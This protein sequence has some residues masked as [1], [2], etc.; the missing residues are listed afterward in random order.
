MVVDTSWFIRSKEDLQNTRRYGCWFSGDPIYTY[1]K[2]LDRNHWLHK[3]PGKKRADGSL[4]LMDSFFDQPL[5]EDVARQA[6]QIFFLSSRVAISYSLSKILSSNMNKVIVMSSFSDVS[7]IQFI[8]TSKLIEETTRRRLRSK[9]TKTFEGGLYGQLYEQFLLEWN[10]IRTSRNFFDNV[11]SLVDESVKVDNLKLDYFESLLC[12]LFAF[13]FIIFLPFILQ[14]VLELWKKRGYPCIALN[15][16]M[17]DFN[18]KIVLKYPIFRRRFPRIAFNRYS[19]SFNV[20]IV[21]KYPTFR[22]R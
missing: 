20:K 17:I 22:R 3:L 7:L 10:T 5:I 4:C 11:Q 14:V 13:Y 21:L 15:R 6:T 16:Y 12:Y 2:S 8:Y 18:V 9:L 19:N 1:I